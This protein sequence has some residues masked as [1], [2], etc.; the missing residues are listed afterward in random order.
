[1]AT[2][3]PVAKPLFTKTAIAVFLAVAWVGGSA[4]VARADLTGNVN[5][6]LGAKAL[7]EDDWAPVE[8]QGE[9]AIEF[10]FRERT[11]PLNLVIGLRG[12]HDEDDLGGVTVE[13]TTSELSLG[14]RKIWEPDA[15]IRPFLGGG[16]ALI[17]AE[18]KATAFG[19]ASSSDTAPGI[20]LGGG[21]YLALTPHFNLGLDLRVSAAEVTIAGVEGEAGG[22]HLGILLGYHF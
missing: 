20:W 18:A 5:V 11:W 14:V 1:M 7:E 19:T 12:A 8:D 13:S 9:I 22:V 16:L 17:G 6:F 15:I 21:M 10:D 3:R 2:Q 4:Q